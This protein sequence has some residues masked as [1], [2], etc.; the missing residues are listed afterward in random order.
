MAGK[1]RVQILGGLGNQLF[2]L[3]LDQ[4]TI[5]KKLHLIHLLISSSEES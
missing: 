4:F 1:V 3:P 2:N 5:I